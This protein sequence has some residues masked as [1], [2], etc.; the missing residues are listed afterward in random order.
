M[1]SPKFHSKNQLQWSTIPTD[2]YQSAYTPLPS[3]D[4]N[5]NDGGFITDDNYDGGSEV[6]SRRINIA[7]AMWESYLEYKANGG[8]V[9]SDDDF[10][11]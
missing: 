3:N 7:N 11:E 6:E 9:D 8:T 2:P 10:S 4:D 1:C 5:D